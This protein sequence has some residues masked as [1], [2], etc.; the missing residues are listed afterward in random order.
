V[1]AVDSTTKTTIIQS[2]Q[3]GRLEI[4]ED[5]IICFHRGIP[6]FDHL[7]KFAIFDSEDMKPF[8]WLISLEESNLGFVIVPPQIICPSYQPKLFES[9]LI[10]LN[11]DQED[12]LALFV[13]VTL[14]TDPTKSTANLQGPLLINLNK[15]TGKQIVVV[16]EKYS[17]KYPILRSEDNGSNGKN[18]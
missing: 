13:I 6:G 5:E 16:D 11:V 7:H 18:K 17:V 2:K 9:D 8:Q 14:A 1:I 4:D 10:E 12:Q 3:W 15:R